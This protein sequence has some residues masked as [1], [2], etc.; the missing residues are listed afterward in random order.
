MRGKPFAAGNT[1]GKGRQRGSR[2]KRTKLMELMEDHGEAMIK[3]CQILALNGD[4]T[5]LRLCV[6]RLIPPCR[7]S[8]NQ[9]RLPPMKT[10]ADL[11]EV[12]PAVAREVARGRLSAQDGEAFSR[13]IE[14]QRRTIES[15]E[16][17][18]RL[19]VI[20]KAQKRGPRQPRKTP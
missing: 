2:N 12:L 3:Q 19:R 11:G 18:K 9:F 16:F 17:E 10:M 13:M 15:E 4:P 14:T 7:A 1:F 5:A 20:E 8:R 6:E